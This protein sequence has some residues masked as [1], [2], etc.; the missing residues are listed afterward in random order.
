[1]NEL[2]RKDCHIPQECKVTI[3]KKPSTAAQRT[4]PDMLDFDSFFGWVVSVYDPKN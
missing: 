3:K 2:H 4:P 1:M